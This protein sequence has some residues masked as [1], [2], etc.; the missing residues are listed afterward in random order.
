MRVG[1]TF[2]IL[3]ATANRE[4]TSKG[5]RRI[6]GQTKK[7]GNSLSTIDTI[8]DSGSGVFPSPG[9]FGLSSVTNSRCALAVEIKWC[10][11][12]TDGGLT[13]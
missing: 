8:P 11:G 5:V 13:R 2:G 1:S 3:A 7:R 9:E 12:I 10:S 4:R 6:L